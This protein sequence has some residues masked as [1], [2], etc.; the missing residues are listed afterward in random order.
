MVEEMAAERGGPDHGV[1]GRSAE[2]EGREG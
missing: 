2:V 1:G